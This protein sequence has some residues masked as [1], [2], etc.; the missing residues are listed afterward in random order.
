MR[1]QRQDGWTKEEDVLLTETVLRHIQTGKTQLEAFKQAAEALSRTPAACGYRWNATIRQQ[2]LEAID[3]A[4]NNRKKKSQLDSLALHDDDKQILDSVISML[5]NIK[6]PNLHTN[7]TVDSATLRRL[8][9]LQVE[10]QKLQQEVNKYREAWQEMNHVWNWIE[11]S[12][13]H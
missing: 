11:K 9:H 7:A 2:H 8:H 1:K 5:E 12:N 13:E 3:L 4:R 10:N 6:S